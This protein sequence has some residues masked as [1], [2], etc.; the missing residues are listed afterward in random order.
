[1]NSTE[2]TLRAVRTQVQFHLAQTAAEVAQAAALCVAA[3]RRVD[4]LS[5]RCQSAA[6]ATHTAQA[7]VAIDPALLAAMH[8]LLNTEQHALH[9]ARVQLEALTQREQQARSALAE[10]RNRDRSVERAL[11]SAQRGQQLEQQAREM[12]RA[13]DQWLQL[14]WRSRP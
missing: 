2:R 6:R 11:K 12:I 5:E 9:G 3:Q 8:G 7:R 13:D 10:V 4:A 1:M 14:Q